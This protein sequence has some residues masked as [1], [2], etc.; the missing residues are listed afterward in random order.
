MFI[1]TS[2]SQFVLKFVSINALILCVFFFFNRLYSKGR[3][4][5][6]NQP[7]FEKV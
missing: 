6:I 2:I 3:H 1:C 4:C 7:F 5:G